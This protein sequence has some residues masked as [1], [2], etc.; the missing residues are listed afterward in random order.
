MPFLSAR[1]ALLKYGWKPSKSNKQCLGITT[2][3]GEAADL[4][5]DAR[6]LKRP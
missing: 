5:I 3:G 2:A 4:I 6:D 1:K